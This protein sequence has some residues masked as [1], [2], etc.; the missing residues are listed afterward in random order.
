MVVMRVQQIR[1]QE[2]I[3]VTRSHLAGCVLGFALLGWNCFRFPWDV[4]KQVFRL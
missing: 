2:Q 1:L 3:A 4:A